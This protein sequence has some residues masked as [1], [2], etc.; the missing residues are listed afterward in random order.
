MDLSARKDVQ[1][2]IFGALD[3]APSSKSGLLSRL[4]RKHGVSEFVSWRVLVDMVDRGLVREQFTAS[5]QRLYFIPGQAPASSGRTIVSANRD[6]VR[7]T[8]LED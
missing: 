1:N 5:A 7:F 4:R 6:G 3:G 2:L 8:S